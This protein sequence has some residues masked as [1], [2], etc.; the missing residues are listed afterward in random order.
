MASF[1]ITVLSKPHSGRIFATVLAET[2]LYAHHKDGGKNNSAFNAE[3]IGKVV[4]KTMI[5]IGRKPNT[6]GV[7]K[8]LI[9][10]MIAAVL[11]GREKNS[12]T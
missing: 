5:N 4:L 12:P 7:F 11:E 1:F 9:R 6:C 10:T 3:I 8:I 2:P